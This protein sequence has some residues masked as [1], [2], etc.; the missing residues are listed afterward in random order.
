MLSVGTHHGDRL[1]PEIWIC[2]RGNNSLLRTSRQ[3]KSIEVASRVSPARRGIT[4]ITNCHID[5]YIYNKKDS[6][7]RITVREQHCFI[8][9][10]CVDLSKSIEGLDGDESWHG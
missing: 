2:S 10:S 8:S 6:S 3:Q 1:A 4:A 5:L 7:D 9:V